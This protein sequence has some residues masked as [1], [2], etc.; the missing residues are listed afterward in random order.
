MVTRS[1][2]SLVSVAASD[3][4]GTVDDDDEDD[5]DDDDDDDKKEASKKNWR[6]EE[7][8]KQRVYEYETVFWGK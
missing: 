8:N 7:E 6:K 1:A 4:S 5:D 3:W 2:R